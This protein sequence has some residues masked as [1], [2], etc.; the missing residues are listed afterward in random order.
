MWS[1]KGQAVKEGNSEGSTE[2]WKPNRTGTPDSMLQ[3]AGYVDLLA[4]IMGVTHMAVKEKGSNI[5]DALFWILWL[6]Q[7]RFGAF[8][9]TW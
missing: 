8:T 6:T 9:L 7:W 1:A 4:P 2:L 5:R 3:T